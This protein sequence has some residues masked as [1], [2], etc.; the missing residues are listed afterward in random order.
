MKIN[1]LKVWI[2]TCCLFVGLSACEKKKSNQYAQKFKL[3]FAY[4]TDVHLNIIM[5]MEMKV[6]YFEKIGKEMPAFLFMSRYF[7]F[8]IR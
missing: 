7:R 2:I 5:D 4:L 3:I 6:S 1:L 8:I